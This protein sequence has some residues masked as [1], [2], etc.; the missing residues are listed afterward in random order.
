[1]YINICMHACVCVYACMC[2]I[3]LDILTKIKSPSEQGT[4]DYETST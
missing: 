3:Q 1:M 2:V 4:K